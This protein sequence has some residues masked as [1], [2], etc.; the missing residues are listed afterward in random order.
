LVSST[1]ILQ[2]FSK[3]RSA[4]NNQQ[5]LTP[6]YKSLLA[7]LGNPHQKLPPVFHVAGTNGKGSTCAF[8][9][10]ILEAAGYTVHVYTSPHLVN[11]HERIRIAGNLIRE[12]ELVTLL[13]ECERL[14]EKKEVS[15]FEVITAAA[16]A[17][18]A[19]HPA[20]F[21]ILETG[22]GGRLDATNVV[23]E[24][25]ATLITRLSY[26]HRNF[27]GD[28]LKQIAA[29]KAGIMRTGIPCF[30]NAQ[31]DVESIE[32][33]R[34]I[35]AEKGAPLFVG[36]DAWKVMPKHSGFHFKDAQRDFDLPQP[37]LAGAHQYQ[38]AG[39]AIAALSV[40]PKPIAQEMIA[41]GLKKVEWPA[42]LQRLDR[43]ALSQLLAQKQEL[44]LDGGHNDS[45]GEV[46]AAQAESWKK[47]DG[48]KSRPLYLIYG[49]LTT[50]EP[51]EF[52]QQLFKHVA[53][54]RTIPIP[55]EPLSFAA[56]ALAD[57]TRNCGIDNVKPVLSLQD[58]LKEL[59]ALSPHARILI[60]GSLYLAGYA[61]RENGV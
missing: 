12:E 54:V 58:A 11:F 35:A 29:E 18:F 19:K 61:L 23:E 51:Q 45:A 13:L 28:T 60:C 59:S 39:L 37:A 2:R 26:D 42:R 27:L 32:T 25:L 30:V 53:A 1:E 43:G 40:L 50:K 34:T 31:P 15:E 8:L 52:L 10:S 38:N 56:D 36:G 47:V 20:D 6:A 22:L 55:D 24:P 57:K 48:D 9:R 21:V 33:L 41:E 16:F 44:W 3:N 7:K 4:I 14:D 46:L 17:A 5:A 49:M